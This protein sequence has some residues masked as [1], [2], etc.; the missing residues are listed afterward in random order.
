MS[1]LAARQ[2]G[3]FAYFDVHFQGF[4]GIREIYKLLYYLIPIINWHFVFMLV[5]EIAGLYLVLRTLRKLILKNIS[6]IRL[7][8]FIQ[9]LFALFYVENIIFVSH[10]RVSLIFCGIA[11]FNLAFAP[12]IG[13]RDVIRYGLLFI[14]GMLLRPESGI[15]MLLIVGSGYFLYTL[16]VKELIRRIWLPILSMAV[17]LTIFTID[18]AY[19]D[20]YVR[21]VEPEIEY[22]MMARRVVNLDQMKTAKDSVKYEA[23]LVGMWFDMREMTPA[24]MRS[25]IVPGLDRDPHH[26]K[27]VL[28]HVSGFYSDY[29]FLIATIIALFILVLWLPDRKVRLTKMILFQICTAGIIYV[30]DFNGFLV[31]NRHFMSLQFLSLFITCFYFFDAPDIRKVFRSRTLILL[32]LIFLSGALL[33]TLLKYKSENTVVDQK[34]NDMVNTMKKLEQKYTGRIVLIT[35]DSRFLFDQHFSLINEPYRKNTYL[36]FDWFTFPL[37]PRYM[38]Y[39]SA[40]CNCDANDPAAFFRWLA[41][42]DA[43]YVA[44]PYRIISNSDLGTLEKV[45]DTDEVNLAL[46]TNKY[47]HISFTNDIDQIASDPDIEAVVIC[48]PVN[49]HFPLTEKLMLAGKHVLCE[50][51][52]TCSADQCE[53]LYDL[54]KKQGV[55]LLVGHVFEYN[56]VVRY[57]KGMVEQDMIGKMLY[58]QL[59]RMGLG[60]VRKDVSVIFDLAAH[61]VAISIS[62]MG[63]MPLAVSAIGSCF[64]Q[65]TVEDVAFIQLEFPEKVIASISVSWIDPIKQ[66]LVKV[67]GAKKMLVF[68]DV[69]VGEK[70]RII[71]TG[72]NYQTSPGDYGSFQLSVKDGDIVIPN[73][74]YTESLVSEFEHFVACIRRKEELLTDA[75]Y[76]ARVVRVLEAAQDSIRQGG[77]KIML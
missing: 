46:L 11:L 68:D 17:F 67:V 74:Q 60:P 54:A 39:L 26:M 20:I 8:R 58:L 70:L 52:L 47:P 49:T 42:N 32:T 21:K 45:C 16:N 62:L 50:K 40:K 48:T 44:S 13:R 38:H 22:K 34:V 66:R 15:G 9:V 76:A 64:L 10:T 59:M 37:T 4:I 5:Y 25:I 53:Y 1:S 51:P 55:I 77:K 6:S 43:L 41:A 7:I 61:D 36:M 12:A 31:S 2:Y 19:T 73:L 56:S 23:A 27:E 75:L 65:D 29:P 3:D 35:I 57:M 71:D 28:V 63:Q 69:S 14:F 30:L 24:Y 33:L 18:L 72:K